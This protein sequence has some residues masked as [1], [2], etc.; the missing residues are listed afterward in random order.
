MPDITA[1]SNACRTADRFPVTITRTH[2]AE[3]A[4][5]HAQFGT[6]SARSARVT[7]ANRA[8]ALLLRRSGAGAGAVEKKRGECCCR[9]FDVELSLK[10][11]LESA[12]DEAGEEL[13]LGLRAQVG[14]EHAVPDAA[15]EDPAQW[16]AS[17]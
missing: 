4:F 13:E 8:N 10:A 14:P 1:S 2:G 6:R 12:G 15:R 17:V 3:K 5:C 7:T 16:A 11:R 9:L